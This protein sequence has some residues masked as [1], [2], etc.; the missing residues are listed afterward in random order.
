MKLTNKLLNKYYSIRQNG[1][2]SANENY[3][4]EVYKMDR[5]TYNQLTKCHSSALG[6]MGGQM[7][8]KEAKYYWDIV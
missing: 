1:G 7:T 3:N 6:I 4:R 8:L 5:E 2:L